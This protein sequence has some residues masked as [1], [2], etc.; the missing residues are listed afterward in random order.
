LIKKSQKTLTLKIRAS[1]VTKVIF[2]G[3]TMRF[4]VYERL[5]KLEVA[6]SHQD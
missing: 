1:K 3:D 6:N 4:M 2:H 5:C